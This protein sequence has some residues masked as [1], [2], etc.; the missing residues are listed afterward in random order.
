MPII[1]MP[2][3]LLLRLVNRESQVIDEPQ[4]VQ[5]LDDMGVETEEMATTNVYSCLACDNAIERTDAQG[6]PLVC[7]K[8]GTDFRQRGDA[9]KKLGT[10]K[11][12]RLNMLAVR[13]DIFDPGG[14]A[15]YMR[16]FLGAK[17][18]LVDYDVSKCKLAVK[19]D[20]RMSSDASYRPAIACA[21]LRNVKLDN[22]RIKLL[23]NLQ[24]DLHWALGRDRKLASIGVYD[25]DKVNENGP[26]FQYRAVG[27][28]EL[29]F[30][31]LGF[32]MNDPAAKL[33]PRE[34]LEKHKTGVAYA[35]LLKGMTAYPLLTDGDGNVLSMPPIINSEATRVTMQTRQCFVDVTGLAQRTVDRALNILVSGLKEVMPELEIEAVAIEY[36][37]REIVAPSFDAAQMQLEV[38]EACDTLGMEMN[39]DTLA[40]LLE[41]MGHGVTVPG[42][43]R[44]SR[45]WTKGF[46]PTPTTVG[47]S[48]DQVAREL[49]A[50]AAREAEYETLTIHVPAWRNDVMHPIDLIEDAA[51]AL[52]YDKLT[53]QLVP[54][55]TVGQPRAI[56][57]TCAIVRRIFTG[58]GFHQV[59][60]LTLNNATAVAEKWGLSPGDPA[61]EAWLSRAVQIENPI[62]S[63][64]THC[65][66]SLL[67]GI[68]ETLAINKQYELPQNLFEVGD[69]SFVDAAVETGAREERYVAAAMIG[70][71]V[72]YADIR[73]VLDSFLHE[74]SATCRVAA[75][76][77]PSF[78]A[79]RCAAIQNAA[80]AP[81]G[82]MG[83]LH[84]AVLDRHG[85]KHAVTVLEMSVERMR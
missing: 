48:E 71:H 70:T 1:N 10:N 66:A 2:V 42:P 83:E 32:S 45:E 56:E 85:L 3:D 60:T 82:T 13:P 29:R 69:C 28:D 49:A 7:G 18:G 37:D 12:A 72:G 17:T 73:A 61:A 53:P 47:Y 31:P 46:W 79:G 67:P 51:V 25:L 57:E 63:E 34:I 52:G 50:V 19:V 15:R 65:R 76:Q 16:G 4:L 74:M 59:M 30:V 8:C 43:R 84:P 35:H 24:E 20:P 22:E 80:G 6:E 27:P 64:Q 23:M 40:K 33:T 9:L 58:L 54:T 68:L 62:S 77:H 5:T 14:M 39:A 41:R 21:V 81:I 55:F 75:T 44:G 78:I 11:V 26:T 38:T 36:A